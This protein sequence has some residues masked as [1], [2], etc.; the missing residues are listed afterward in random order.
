[1]IISILNQKGGVGKTTLATNLAAALALAGHKTLL[2]DADPQGSSLDW[3]A[4]R[5]EDPLFPVVGMA[6]PT[7][8]KDLPELVVACQHAIIDGPPRAN[9]LTRSAM[10]ASDLVVIPV[11]PSPYDV[12]AADEIV[13]LLQETAIYNPDL[14]G[15]FVIN[16]RISNTAIGRDVIDALQG[17]SLAIAKAVIGQRIAFAESAARGLSVLETAPKSQA[18]LEIKAL[19]RELLTLHG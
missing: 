19:A 3:R 8:Q 6:K 2:I 1:M 18:A 17:Y 12:W 9:E 4:S 16:R 7:L 15:V 11:Q 10:M 5:E 14:K 13:N